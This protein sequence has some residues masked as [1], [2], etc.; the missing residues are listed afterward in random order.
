MNAAALLVVLAS[1][2]GMVGGSYVTVSAV[3]AGAVVSVEVAVDVLA[4][5]SSAL[6]LSFLPS[7]KVVL[8]ATDE[9]LSAAFDRSD[10]LVSAGA[11][12]FP[13]LVYSGAMSVA[14]Q[15]ATF[16]DEIDRS[17]LLPG[18]GSYVAFLV[19]SYAFLLKFGADSYAVAVAAAPKLV[20]AA[21]RVPGLVASMVRSL[22][23]ILAGKSHR[24]VTLL[25]FLLLTIP[26]FAVNQVVLGASM[27]RQ[28]MVGRNNKKNKKRV[29]FNQTA[30]VR[31][32]SVT[33]GDQPEAGK[34]GGCPLSL[35][36][37]SADAK[38]IRLD[39]IELRKVGVLGRYVPPVDRFERI[40]QVSGIDSDELMQDE[41]RRRMEQAEDDRLAAVKTKRVTFNENA[42]VRVYSVTLGDNPCAGKQGGCPLSLDWAYAEAKEVRLDA[43]E[44]GKV[45][46]MRCQLHPAERFDRIVQ[47][48]G[49][50]PDDLVR[51]ERWRQWAQA[52]DDRLAAEVPDKEGDL[53]VSVEEKDESMAA[54]ATVL[55][56]VELCSPEDS[57]FVGGDDDDD[58]DDGDYMD[59]EVDEPPAAEVPVE[60]GEPEG[61]D[62]RGKET[63]VAQ[64]SVPA[65]L[66]CRQEHGP[67]R[68]CDNEDEDDEDEEP[69]PSQ[70]EDESKLAVEPAIHNPDPAMEVLVEALSRLSVRTLEEHRP[71]K[72]AEAKQEQADKDDKKGLSDDKAKTA[73]QEWEEEGN[74]V[75]SNDGKEEEEE[76]DLEV[77]EE[78]EE[79]YCEDKDEKVELDQLPAESFPGSVNFEEDGEPEDDEGKESTPMREHRIGNLV[80]GKHEDSDD[81][82][83]R[84]ESGSKEN[85]V[86]FDGGQ[87]EDEEAESSGGAEVEG[88]AARRR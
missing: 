76:D 73:P 66:V 38:E 65:D 31:E 19:V 47:V 67:F 85:G 56:P 26:L 13:F 18:A 28:M 83:A 37:E 21:A 49:I 1:N 55:P 41:L 17:L 44:Q 86:E 9:V 82:E 77:V 71:T 78:E 80:E 39:E 75:E 3:L 29:T 20:H 48:S 35:D 58:D 63:M 42:K 15:F 81:E 45:G 87:D 2:A 79:G 46:L 32:Y 70:E 60:D 72:L 23:A 36:W 53:E 84:E 62:V 57:P 12:P 25:E 54:P 14:F 69:V 7:I 50:D 51:E 40:V 68:G 16:D 6:F 22:R 10:E 43:L 59:V 74:V 4:A 8:R 52:E 61:E 27:L 33:L 34:R 24:Y 30:Q 88:G 5:A 11:R 64:V